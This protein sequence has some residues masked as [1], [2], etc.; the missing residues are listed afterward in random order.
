MD[1]LITKLRKNRPLIHC[2]VGPVASNFCANGALA[3]GARPI[4]AEHPLEVNEITASAQ[5]LL[6]N[7]SGISDVKMESMKKAAVVAGENGIPTVIDGVGVSCSSLRRRFVFELLNI[8]TPS[9]IKGNYSEIYALHNEKYHS[10]GVDSE[11]GVADDDILSAAINLAKNFNCV[12]L[13]SGE[14]D[15]ITD[16]TRVAKVKN[17]V[18]Q[19]G[20]ITATGCLLGTICACLASQ[21]DPFSAA[22]SACAVLGICGERAEAEGKNGRFMYGLLDELSSIDHK[23]IN[24]MIKI[25]EQYYEKA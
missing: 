8:A 20:N 11:Q 18:A 17:G 9:V 23:K 14:T 15:I 12:V 10:S 19:L 2:I 22:V 5:G 3:I 13:V 6:L 7:L 16:G 21:T 24:E 4:M 25:E 1:D